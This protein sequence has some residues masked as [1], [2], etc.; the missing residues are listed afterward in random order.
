MRNPAAGICLLAF[1]VL[2]SAP[3]F[4]FSQCDPNWKPGQDLPDVSGPVKVF[5]TW[6]PDGAGPKPELLVV[7]GEFITAGGATVNYIAAWDGNSFQPLGTGM[8]GYGV[9]ALTV[10]NGKLIAGG[11]FTKAGDANANY[12]AAWD[13]NSWQP[14]GS[15]MNWGSVGA[16]TVY[17]GRLI[18]GGSFS[19]AGD[20]DAN[21]IAAWDGNSWQ[22]LGSGIDPSG[23]VGALTVYNGRLIAGGCFNTAGGLTA[24]NIAAW[25]GNSWQPLGTGMNNYVIT[26]TVYNSRLIAG[27]YFNTAGGV[28]CHNIAAWD[29][30]SFQ[31]LGTGINDDVYALTVYNGK[32]IAGGYFGRAGSVDANNIAAWDGSTW[33]RLAGG[34]TTRINALANY[35]SR[36]FVGHEF[37]N[38]GYDKYINYWDGSTWRWLGNGFKAESFYAF[39]K[40][41]TV[42]NGK[43]IAAGYFDTVGGVSAHHIAAWSGS[44][45]QPLG[46]GMGFYGSPP[47]GYSLQVNALTDYNNRLIAGGIFNRVGGAS[48]YYISANDI[49][50]WDGNSWHSLGSG[51]SGTYPY[52]Y[53]LTVYNGSLIVG[54]TFTKCITSWNGSSWRL[55]GSG[56]AGSNPCVYALTVYNGK[57]IAGGLFTTAGGVTVS[58]IA[59]WDGSVWQ[60]LGSGMNNIVYS[61]TVYNGQLIAGGS[62][63][64]AGGVSAN[65]IAVWDGNSFQP[66]GNGMNKPVASLTV[67][68]SRLIAAGG[69]F[70]T[71]GG[72]DA[73][74]IASWDGISWQPL[75]SG[76]GPNSVTTSVAA[77]TP[78]NG[79]L[80]AGGSFGYAGIYPSLNWAKWGVPQPI[81]GDLNHDCAVNLFDLRILADNWLRRDC[82]YT[83]FC[84]EAD[85]NY[86]HQIDFLDFTLFTDNWLGCFVKPS[87][88]PNPANGA[89]NVN[90]NAILRWSA[91]Q[92][93]LEHDVYFGTDANAVAE[94]NHLS[95]QFMATVS[96]VNFNSSLLDSN[97][98]Y[99]WRID[100]V[101]PRCTIKG[102]IWNFKTWFI[103]DLNPVGWWK[104]DEASGRIVHD[105]SGHNNN[106]TV[107]GVATWTTGQIN[108]ALNFDGSYSYVNVPDNDNSLDIPSQITI[109]AWVKPNDHS[110]YYCIAAKQPS[111]TAPNSSSGNYDFRIA[112]DSGVLQFL[113]QTGTGDTA[114]AYSS[115]SAV[116][117][118]TW[119]HVAVT[120]KQGDSV[121]FYING[122]SAGTL[123]QTEAF[124]IVNDNPLRIGSKADYL[125]WFN[126]PMD[127]VRIYNMALSDFEIQQ[128]YLYGSTP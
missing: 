99:F 5:T 39:L 12:I 32:L 11:Y 97:T 96:E 85:L 42:Y 115:T 72:V 114:V 87:R 84:N 49:A 69:G 125:D 75:G 117:T 100:E 76:I 56:I 10:Y 17:N 57:L 29:G 110:D 105:S 14:L 63:T 93:A 116:S 118:G 33:Q 47:S 41:F 25:D 122:A 3:H 18:A 103:R 71:A 95:P 80:I 13:G 73:N 23:G 78:Y 83:G 120:L 31:P 16:L 44:G 81:Q 9:Y 106:G 26:L 20:V 82:K 124:G 58:N 60:P 94:A 104:F 86:D 38:S 24:N 121:K 91:G 101:G 126:G 119:Q 45:W 27:G 111:G 70:T 64:T 4:C 74:H 43:L 51:M 90:L 108:G 68:N 67:Y 109:T 112:Q 52:V 7:G 28:S 55:L 40:A 113:H 102:I 59:A 35:K 50:A 15:G 19:K 30:N 66:L 92:G 37:L 123:P 127:D 6:D 89:T 21:N 65:R 79:D 98:T 48:G 107:N 61:L 8:N 2:T 77:L 54:G 88:N 1:I 36:L 128:L 53:A 62:F 34:S 22:P 46:L